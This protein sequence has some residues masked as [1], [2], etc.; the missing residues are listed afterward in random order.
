VD[1]WLTRTQAKSSGSCAGKHCQTEDKQKKSSSADCSV[2]LSTASVVS[3]SNNYGGNYSYAVRTSHFLSAECERALCY[4]H[5]DGTKIG[6]YGCH[7]VRLV[8]NDDCASTVIT[9]LEMQ[10]QLERNVSTIQQLRYDFEGSQQSQLVL[11]YIWKIH[12]EYGADIS[13][14]VHL[15][16]WRM[17]GKVLCHMCWAAAA[18]FL[19]SPNMERKKECM[20]NAVKTYYQG[21]KVIMERPHITEP[22]GTKGGKLNHAVAYLNSYV[23]KKSCNAQQL[24]TDSNQHI[25]GISEKELYLDYIEGLKQSEPGVV[26]PTAS[27]LS[28]FRRARLYMNEEPTMPTIAFNKWSA[29]QECAVCSALKIMKQRAAASHNQQRVDLLIERFKM[30]RLIAQLERMSMDIHEE[31]GKKKLDEVSGG[32]DGFCSFK[33]S[34]F[35]HHGHSMSDWKAVAGMGSAEG[36]SFK[37]TA[38]VFH[39]WGYWLYVADPRVAVNANYNVHVLHLSL[40]A[41]FKKVKEDPDANWPTVF[42]FQIDGASDNKARVLFMY[43]EYLVR[44]NVFD[45]IYVNFL[46]V[47]HTHNFIDQRFVAI[48][49]QLRREVVKCLQDYLDSVARSYT[50]PN[51]KP[52]EVI[53]V[54]FVPDYTKWL[55]VDCGDKFEG[56]ALRTPDELRPH[57]FVFKVT[58]VSTEPDTCFVN[59]TRGCKLDYKNLT[60]DGAPWNEGQGTIC[61]L[62]KL[63][64]TPKPP[65]QNPSK[66]PDP[67]PDPNPSPN[68]DPDPNPNPNPNPTQE[69][70]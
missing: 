17:S 4:M 39:G 60:I 22:K 68:P 29:Q 12:A 3:K 33:S 58:H 51:C 5:P 18:G 11:D 1:A 54:D 46:I 2:N 13:V 41:L 38:I 53:V 15:L 8:K 59:Q 57:Q 65:M 20:A 23:D 70:N 7:G 67:N 32:G 28:T 30:H 66:G 9:D 6:Q 16:P 40:H 10:K 21:R 45:V 24:T 56:F 35:M 48:T 55:V 61:L 43:M 31:K 36:Y 34:N 47:G 63:P 50:D 25:Q 49:K 14:S 26:K 37:T 19:T 44:T 42:H 27:S 64:D 62:W 69:H 52:T